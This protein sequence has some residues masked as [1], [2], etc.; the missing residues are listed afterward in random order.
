MTRSA[1][2]F[3]VTRGVAKMTGSLLATRSFICLFVL[4]TAAHAHENI[5]DVAQD[6]VAWRAECGACHMAFP[7]GMLSSGEW[8]EI[9]SDLKSHF[10]VDASLDT[11]IQ[12]DIARYLEQH[13]A[14]SNRHDRLG[15]MP[16]ITC[17]L[18]TSP[19]PRD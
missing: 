10:G 4:G 2:E 18:Y 6:N 12:Q 3:S 15:T 11:P 7:P 8:S 5:W 9:M 14:A 16:R 1:V 13:G 19:S 17:L